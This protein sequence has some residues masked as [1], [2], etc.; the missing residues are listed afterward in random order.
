MTI[1]VLGVGQ[2]MRSDDAA[3]LEIVRLWE[4][5]HPEVAKRVI[6]EYAEHTGL[7]LLDL[8]SKANF[9]IIVDAIQSSET[10]GTLIRLE[11]DD[12]EKFTSD[13]KSSHGWGLAETLQMGM[14]LHLSMA[15]VQI[16]LIG[17][18]AHDFLPGKEFSPQILSRFPDAVK[19]LENEVDRLFRAPSSRV[20]EIK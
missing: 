16:I 7:E 15:D 10:P 3:G 6:V 14:S 5:T 18:V 20:N 4:E 17:V 8:L 19:M 9:A 1:L 2:S 13:T 12:L 11:L